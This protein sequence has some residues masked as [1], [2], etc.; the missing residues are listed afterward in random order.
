MMPY[1]L[2][3]LPYPQDNHKLKFSELLRRHAE[4]AIKLK[5]SK[6]YYKTR[7]KRLKEENRAMKLQIEQMVNNNIQTDEMPLP[8]TN[9]HADDRKSKKTN[10]RGKSYDIIILSP[11]KIED[12]LPSLSKH[13]VKNISQSQKTSEDLVAESGK[14]LR[15]SSSTN[16]DKKSRI[17]STMHHSSM[18]KLDD[19]DISKD[20]D[21]NIGIVRQRR[22]PST[23]GH[24]FKIFESGGFSIKPFTI[25][26]HHKDQH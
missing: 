5:E 20:Y 19:E 1:S 10:R 9:N 7:N 17:S 23:S 25:N 26:R 4:K 21:S 24:S 11:T 3:F 15:P 13:K 14:R 16:T 2:P 8:N 6:N 12:R 22:L 18:S